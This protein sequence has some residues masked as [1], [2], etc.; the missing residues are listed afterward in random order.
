M[1]KTFLIAYDLNKGETSSEYLRLIKE[2]K[3][4]GTWAKPLESTWLVVT[5]GSAATVRDHLNKFIDSNDELLVMDVS[6][7]D[8]GTYG[9]NADVT[10]WMNAN[11]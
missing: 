4:L 2:I 7:D 5:T 6:G 8:W 10:K 11:I 3:E 1:N 9:I